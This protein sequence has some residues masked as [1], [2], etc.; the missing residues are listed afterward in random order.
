MPGTL[1][2]FCGKMGAGKST[3]AQALARADHTVLISED[4]WLS[5]LYPT[6][7]QTFEDYLHY[8]F[9]LK[10]LLKPHIQSLLNTGISV[11]LDFPGNT[12]KQRAW[13]KVLIEDIGTPHRLIYL[14]AT[15][16][17]CLE[18]LSERRTKHPERSAFDNEATFKHVTALFEA[19]TPEEGFHIE[20]IM[21]DKP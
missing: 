21:Q 4:E 7:I 9:R 12:Q 20:S 1:I 2:F 6:E 5:Q 11:V 16:A 8:A 19:P 14:K 18:R 10:A 13:F 3:K 17:W 15:D